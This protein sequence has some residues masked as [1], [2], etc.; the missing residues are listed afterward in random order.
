MNSVNYCDFV[1]LVLCEF[2]DY[3]FNDYMGCHSHLKIVVLLI[4]N[5]D[6]VG[7]GCS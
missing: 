5:C 4:M 1:Q 7:S 3:M 2:D 6:V